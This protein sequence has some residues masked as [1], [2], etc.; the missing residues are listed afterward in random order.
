MRELPLRIA[1]G[2]SQFA[3]LRQSG[4]ADRGAGIRD[5]TNYQPLHGTPLFVLA[6]G[7]VTRSRVHT[8][9]PL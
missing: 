4:R 8:L 9:L 3:A 6:A 7:I 1:V 5:S 2:C